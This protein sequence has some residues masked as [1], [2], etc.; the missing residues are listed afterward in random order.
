MASHFL[1]EVA[2]FTSGDAWGPA[3]PGGGAFPPGIVER[4]TTDL[5]IYIL[6]EYTRTY[7]VFAAVFF[8]VSLSLLYVVCI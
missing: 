4:G 8:V 3:E 2:K 1:R 6:F 5:S 7:S